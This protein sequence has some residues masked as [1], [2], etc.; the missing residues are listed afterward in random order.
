VL[1]AFAN[2]PQDLQDMEGVITRQGARLNRSLVAEELTPLAEL[3]EEP[4][5]LDQLQAL[6][7]K[8]NG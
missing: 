1:K 7:E 2:H 3:K 8:H 5:V 6:F 4:E